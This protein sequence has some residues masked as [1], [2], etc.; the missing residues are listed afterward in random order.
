MHPNAELISRFYLAFQRRD[1]AGMAACY[2]PE[3]EFSD[4]AFPSLKGREA[5]AMW[6]MLIT[7]GKDLELDFRDVR[8]DEHTGSAHWDA[9]YTFSRTG[10]KVHNRIDAAF[11]FR[12]G[13]IVRHEDRFDFPRWARMAFGPTGWLLGW[14]PFFQ[15]KVQQQA[16]LGLRRHLAG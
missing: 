8:A 2:H 12:D 6:D 10:R 1:A 4:P 5:A 13:L 16:A 3:I 11:R 14:T 7:R 15:R 9:H